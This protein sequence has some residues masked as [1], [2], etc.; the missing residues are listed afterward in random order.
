MLMRDLSWEPFIYWWFWTLESVYYVALTSQNPLLIVI[1]MEVWSPAKDPA[2]Y[3]GDQVKAEYITTFHT[4][5]SR[6]NHR[7][8]IQLHKIVKNVVSLCVLQTE[9]ILVRI[10]QFTS[11]K[12]HT[13]LTIAK[14]L[15]RVDCFS[16]EN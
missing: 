1:R 14:C 11:S 2:G 12:L 5:L 6:N 15:V 4:L 3:F 8:P 10:C 13:F 7:V 9:T 16:L